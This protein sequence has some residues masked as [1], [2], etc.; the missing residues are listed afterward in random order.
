MRPHDVEV[1]QTYRVHITQRDNPAQY[2]TGDPDRTEADLLIFS[3]LL[4]SV[5]EF[6]LT[7]T[8]IGQTLGDEPAVT[9]V[10]VSETSRVS[11]PLPPEMAA[12]M[13]LP[14]NVGYIVEGVL[15]D[16]VTGRIV[17]RPTDQ[18]MTIPCAWLR[19]LT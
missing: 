12:R 5:H 18:T 13:G 19:P 6:D 4:D 8:A 1:G 16:A 7:V 17:S 14:S 2:L 9:G 11:L 10:R 15:K 3:F